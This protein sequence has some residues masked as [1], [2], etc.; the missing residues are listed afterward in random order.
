M[1]TK[2]LSTDRENY[3]SL[4]EAMEI[5]GVKYDAI[6]SATRNGILTATR[7]KGC[8]Q[9]LFVLKI[10][11]EALRG[12]GEVTSVGARARVNE[13]RNTNRDYFAEELSYGAPIKNIPIDYAVK[14]LYQKDPPGFMSALGDY[15][16]AR[17]LIEYVR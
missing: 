10:E 9:H 16:C 6:T 5:I 12:L 2:T 11:V 7:I 17:I 13:V 14:T 8:G 3:Y 4:K 1:A 15:L